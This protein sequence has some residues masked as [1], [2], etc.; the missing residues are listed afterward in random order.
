VPSHTARTACPVSFAGGGRGFCGPLISL[1][2]CDTICYTVSR[3]TCKGGFLVKHK[4]ILWL[5]AL[6]TVL[7]LECLPWGVV[8]TFAAPHGASY[9]STYAYFS[10]IPYGYAN[11]SPLITAILSV[12]L[13]LPIGIAMFKQSRRVSKVI[14]TLA[15]A[16]TVTSVFPFIWGF[17]HIT[18]IGAA[19][20]LLLATIAVTCRD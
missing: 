9:R 12:V 3:N 13:L 7:I 17:D 16:A 5:V 19:I 10:G 15:W 8:M 1:Y 2:K 6:V 18:V 11:F 4:R 20:T 14:C